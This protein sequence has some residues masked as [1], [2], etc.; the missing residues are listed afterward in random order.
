MQELPAHRSCGKH[1]SLNV[2]EP[3]VPEL[4]DDMDFSTPGA[5]SVSR[6]G[7]PKAVQINL[8]QKRGSTFNPE[9]SVDSDSPLKEKQMKLQS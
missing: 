1:T 7:T 3:Q 4:I 6:K 5:V 8:L 2:S 9:D